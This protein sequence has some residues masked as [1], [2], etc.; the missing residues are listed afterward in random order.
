MSKVGTSSARAGERP[1]ERPSS[2][3]RREVII[4]KAIEVFARDGYEDS[5]WADVARAVGIGPTALYHYFESK[6]HCLFVILAEALEGHR[7]DFER[8]TK[9]A[10]DFDT[11]LSEALRAGFRL[12]DHEVAR[13][14]IL[15]AEQGR[16]AIRR[17][18]ESEESARML[19]R[20]RLRELEFAWAAYLVRGMEQGVIPE[21]DPA[22]LARALLGMNTSVWHWYRPGGTV[23][24]RQ[25]EDFFVE[26]Q[27]AVAKLGI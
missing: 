17:K 4:A 24:L 13:M 22:M 11:G 9:N 27:L 19:A 8:V 2:A 18:S 26:R 10:Q 21:A 23:P 1:G 7:E 15:V 12:S 14:R 6:V 16:A 3:G 25:V 20:E 5:K